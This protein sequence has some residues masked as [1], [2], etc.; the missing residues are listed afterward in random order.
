MKTKT[1]L[2]AAVSC[3]LTAVSSAFTL[4]FTSVPVGTTI[5]PNLTIN[6]PGYGDVRFSPV[7][8]SE[9]VVDNQYASAPPATTSPSLNFDAGDGVEITFLG[10]EPTD[11]D[12]AWVGASL[13]E[14]FIPAIVSS[15]EFVVTLTN[16]GTP[17][18]GSNSGAGLYQINFN[19]VPE[20]SSALLGV[21]GASMLIIRRKR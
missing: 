16:L 6:V 3:G 13:G 11:I 15:S 8:T 1:M 20:P 17:P 14:T 4:D 18:S 19:Q 7:G 10:L 21:L 12:F 2:I 9:L 5:P